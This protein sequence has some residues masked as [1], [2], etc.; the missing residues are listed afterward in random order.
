[1]LLSNSYTGGPSFQVTA[2][3]PELFAGLVMTSPFAR[4]QPPMSPLVR[5]RA[6][7]I[8]RVAAGWMAN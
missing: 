5:A 3:A 2:Q 6:A 7:V 8:T 1:M 4:L